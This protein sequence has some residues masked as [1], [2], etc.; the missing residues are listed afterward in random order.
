MRWSWQQNSLLREEATGRPRTQVTGSTQQ[1][2]P[3]AVDLQTFVSIESV[4]LQ[5]GN[6]FLDSPPLSILLTINHIKLIKIEPVFSMFVA[7]LKKSVTRSK[8]RILF[9]FV[10]YISRPHKETL[11]CEMN[12]RLEEEDHSSLKT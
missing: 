3:S 2:L 5:N 8:V 7:C 10:Q 11:F 6:T 9:Y 1:A 4:I 12:Q